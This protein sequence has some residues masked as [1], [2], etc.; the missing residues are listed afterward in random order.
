MPCFHLQ[1][2]TGIT[3]NKN[4]K[5]AHYKLEHISDPNISNILKKYILEK[6]FRA[7]TRFGGRTS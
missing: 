6:Y 7:I 1:F 4:K 5:T 2:H 3:H